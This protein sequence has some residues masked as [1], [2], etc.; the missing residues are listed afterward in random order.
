MASRKSPSKLTPREEEPRRR[1]RTPTGVILRLHTDLAANANHP[2]A[3]VDPSTRNRE[4]Q[5]LIASILA[6][7][8]GGTISETRPVD[9]MNE[10]EDQSTSQSFEV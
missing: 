5:Q 9:T 3:N 10:S 2:L 4:R 6:R 1:T 7:L 8:A